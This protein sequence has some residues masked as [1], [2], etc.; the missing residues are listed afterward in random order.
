MIEIDHTVV[1][2]IVIGIVTVVEIGDVVGRGGGG[3]GGGRTRSCSD[4]SSRD[5]DRNDNT[6]VAVAMAAEMRIAVKVVAETRS[7]EDRVTIAVVVVVDR[8]VDV[9]MEDVDVVEV[10]VVA[11]GHRLEEGAIR[12]IRMRAG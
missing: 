11:A 3:G 12:E 4:S 7:I 1:N 6:Q 5:R 2:K 9:V 10:V 8:G